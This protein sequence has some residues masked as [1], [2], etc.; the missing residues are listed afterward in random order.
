MVMR[1]AQVISPASLTMSICQTWVL[2]PM[3][4]A[5]KP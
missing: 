5:L 3:C 2:R 1:D 4:T